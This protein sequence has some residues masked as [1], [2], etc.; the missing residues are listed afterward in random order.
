MGF[1][2]MLIL[3]LGLSLLVGCSAI[4]GSKKDL[5]KEGYTQGVR[6]QVKQIAAQFQGGNFPYYHWS[7]PIVQEVRVPAHVGDGV[8]IP[9]H[10]E[11]VIIKPGQ[12]TISPAYPIKT[13]ERNNYDNQVS[14][15]DMDIS[16][17]TS[18]PQSMGKSK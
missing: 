17:I 7:S 15:M 12:W 14:Y 8:L 5:Y 16:N 9:E 4:S 3:I 11:L 1:D 6:E 2:K 10:N 13:N 18:L